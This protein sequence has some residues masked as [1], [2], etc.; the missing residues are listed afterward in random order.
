MLEMIVEA[1]PAN[2]GSVSGSRDSVAAA[3]AVMLGGAA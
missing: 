3:V 1:M 2:R